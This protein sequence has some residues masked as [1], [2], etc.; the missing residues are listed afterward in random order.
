[1]MVKKSLISL[2]L[3]GLSVLCLCFSLSQ[4]AVAQP[5]A[6][7]QDIAA[8]LGLYQTE[9]ENVLIRERSGKLELL[10]GVTAGDY[11][12]NWSNV[13]QLPKSRYD[14]YTVITANPRD[15]NGTLLLKF[16]RDKQGQGI[17]CVID[18]KRYTRIF[19][20]GEKGDVFT[21]KPTQTADVLRA[22]ALNAQL[23]VQA[24]NLLTATLVDIRSLDKSIQ[25]EMIYARE[26]NFL[27]M[28]MYEE[29][30]AFLEQNTAEA[31]LRVNK[32]LA[33]FGLGLVV[34]DAYRPWYVTK[35]FYDALPAEQKKLLEDPLKGSVHNR[36]TAVDVSLYD[37]STGKS[38]TMISGLDEPS[39]RAYRDFQGSSE[40][41]RWRRD[42]LRLVMES[43]GF[44]GVDYEWWHYEYKDAAQYKLLNVR[45]SEIK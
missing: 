4:P 30:R 22:N 21:V 33:G 16:E 14:E 15:Y 5:K 29:E 20:D 9:G 12:F 45:F 43:E 35:M 42:L 31:L 40:Q 19:F 38:V 34:W 6:A 13:Y 3:K 25:V 17:T 37:L 32:K 11:A 24:G 27:G 39:L 36:G 41:L 26:N 44:S 2:L 8:L 28:K 1:M 18:K 23:P 10:Y 7:Q